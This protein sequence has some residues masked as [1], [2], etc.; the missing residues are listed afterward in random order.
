[1]FF[2]ILAL[3]LVIPIVELYVI[4]Q[5]AGAIGVFETIVALVAISVAGAWLVK[6]EGLG[7]ARR[8]QDQLQAGEVP[9]GGVVDGLLILGAGVL[10]LAP[11]FLSDIAGI[12]LLI[13]FTRAPVRAL[14]L[15]RFRQRLS[16]F[17]VAGPGGAGGAGVR[18][19]AGRIYDVDGRE[20]HPAGPTGPAS[21]R[22][23]PE[24]GPG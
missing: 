13:P 8:I 1:V 12:L 9:A 5:V 14:V 11:G 3:L 2:L 16:V 18:F 4:V 22:S 15:R 6:R 7:V 23:P 24:L 21:D 20:N 17:A 10:M 19:G